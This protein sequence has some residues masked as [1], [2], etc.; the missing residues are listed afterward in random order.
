MNRGD[1]RREIRERFVALFDLPNQNLCGCPCGLGKCCVLLGQIEKLVGA[2]NAFGG[3]N[4]ELRKMAARAALI[5]IVFCL[6]KSS[7]V[8]CSISATWLSAL[9]TGTKRM[10][11]PQQ[12]FAD[13][14]GV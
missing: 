13:R 6:T 3:D 10:G 4:A 2:A 9:L 5:L 7:R 11:S 12:S 1:F 8:L 14:L